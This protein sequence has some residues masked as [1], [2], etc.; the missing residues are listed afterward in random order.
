MDPLSLSCNIIGVLTAAGQLISAGYSYGSSVKDFPQEIRD[1]VGELSTL[2][3]ILH[4]LKALMD[5]S[6]DGTTPDTNPS[7]IA[8]A[9]EVPIKDCEKMLENMLG[10]LDNYQKP[11]NKVKN[12]VKRLTWP[13]KEGET[14][15]WIEKISRYKATFSLAL[16]ADGM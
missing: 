2:S 8:K 11:D 9:I 15:S 13:L 14:K 5:S 3:G 1:L 16:S 7:D 4:A 12:F 6:A 10:C